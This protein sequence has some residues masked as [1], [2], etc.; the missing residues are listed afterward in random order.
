MNDDYK[1][2]FDISLTTKQLREAWECVPDL[3][4]GELIEEVFGGSLH[5]LG[6]EDARE[7]LNDFILQNQ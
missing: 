2:P 4:L 3:S 1:E 6:A 5:E 7:M